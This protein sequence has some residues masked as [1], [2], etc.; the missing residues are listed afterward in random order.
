[1][2]SSTVLCTTCSVDRTRVILAGIC[3]LI[4]TVGLARFAYTPL[5]PI[6][7]DGAGLS[8]FAGGWLATFNYLGYMAGAL[9]AATTNDLQRKFRFYRAGLLIAVIST[10]A[11]GLTDNLYLWATLRFIAGVS[12]AAGLLIA[13]GLVLNWLINHGHKPELGL[14]FAGLGAGIVVSGLA[15][16]TMVGAL[17]W[18]SQ[19]IGLGLLGILFF[20]PAWF[21]LPAPV[22]VRANKGASTQPSSA[23]SATWMWL[24]IAAYFCAGVGFVISATFIVAI[25]EQLPVFSGNGP[26]VWV[27]VGLAA[28]PASFLWD[29]VAGWVGGLTALLMAYALQILS[30]LL[31]AVSGGA[32]V[33]LL[34]AGLFGFTFVGIVS[35]TLSIIGRHFPANPSKAM[36]R[37]TL[38]YGVAQ[39]VAPAMAGYIAMVSGSYRGALFI[40]A[41]VMAAGMLLLVLIMRQERRELTSAC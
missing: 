17:A 18:D 14:H 13:S 39:V 23:P 7:R 41:G 2:S 29:R 27:V 1:M 36:A 34:S 4:L 25:V 19:W 10:A 22:P 40:A 33:N 16:S 31:P 5:L 11:M 12:S 15:V 38:S 28:A 32:F 37:L 6:M 20:L 3:A 21:W 30:I 35:L 26:W 9:L 8:D 24:F